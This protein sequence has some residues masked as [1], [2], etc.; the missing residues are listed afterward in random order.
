MKGS[1]KYPLWLGCFLL[2]CAAAV[3][4]R[5]AYVHHES[6]VWADRPPADPRVLHYDGHLYRYD[7][8]A[9][10]TDVDFVKRVQDT[11]G[12]YVYAPALADAPAVIQVRDLGRIYDYRLAG[13]SWSA[14]ERVVPGVVTTV[15]RR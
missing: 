13:A 3:G 8:T 9:R 1:L 2:V 12:G 7:G 6:G 4:V 10:H 11:G 15:R 14:G 5:Y